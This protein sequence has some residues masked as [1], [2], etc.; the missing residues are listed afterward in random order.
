MGKINYLPYYSFKAKPT[1]QIF[2]ENVFTRRSLAT[3]LK[4]I[5]L[6]LRFIIELNDEPVLSNFLSTQSTH[7]SP[8]IWLSQLFLQ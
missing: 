6:Q 4:Y 5:K 2:M 7:A 1:E 3:M 8:G